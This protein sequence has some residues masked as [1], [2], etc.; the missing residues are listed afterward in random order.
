MPFDYLESPDPACYKHAPE[1]AEA[2]YLREL[3]ERAALLSRLHHDRDTA[4]KR[5]MG[6]I[7][8]DWECIPNPEFVA[9]LRA[10]VPDII[11]RVY[12]R[13][14]PPDKGR[15]VTAESLKIAPSD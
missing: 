10:A 13:P 12:S 9:R 8:W 11:E 5:L 14:R 3:E 4:T 1:K 6:N 2:Q 15:R 7:S